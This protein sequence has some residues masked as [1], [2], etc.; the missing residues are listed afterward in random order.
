MLLIFIDKFLKLV[1]LVLNKL[2]N[3][4]ENQTQEL[5]D[6]L[7]LYNQGIFEAIIS[8]RDFKFIFIF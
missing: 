2:T 5:F 1:K 6:F 8:D 7:P 3:S 4:V